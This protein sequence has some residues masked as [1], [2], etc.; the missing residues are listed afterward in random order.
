MKSKKES[1]ADE[2]KYAKPYPHQH[3]KL[4]ILVILLISIGLILFN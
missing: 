1:L 3:K 2:K 4:I